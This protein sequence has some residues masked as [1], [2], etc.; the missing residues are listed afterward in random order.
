MVT[1]IVIIK[2]G[3]FEIEMSAFKYMDFYLLENSTNKWYKTTGFKYL[4]TKY[5]SLP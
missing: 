4:L 2:A 1:G 3:T 5:V